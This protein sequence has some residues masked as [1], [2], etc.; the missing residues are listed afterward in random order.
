[1]DRKL[2]E[3]PE[4]TFCRLLKNLQG[5]VLYIKTEI[6]R[7]NPSFVMKDSERVN[8]EYV[9]ETWDD[10]SARLDESMELLATKFA[11]VN[12]TIVFPISDSQEILVIAQQLKSLEKESHN[13]YLS[14][15]PEHLYLMTTMEEL[16]E[17]APDAWLW[18]TISDK[19]NTS[20]Q[21]LSS[22]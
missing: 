12:W 1:M 15:C 10:V 17:G 5:C 11:S 14:C 6:K 22:C 16:K 7:N 21:M 19:M 9:P 3:E 4:I 20:V 8:S 2:K 13:K 18:K